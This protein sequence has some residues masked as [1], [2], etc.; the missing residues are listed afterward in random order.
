ML[1]TANGIGRTPL[2]NTLL[3]PFK[4]KY[5]TEYQCCLAHVL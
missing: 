5:R 1:Q 4:N 2:M 3:Q